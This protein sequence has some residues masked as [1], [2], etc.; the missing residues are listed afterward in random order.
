MCFAVIPYNSN[1]YIF[2]SHSCDNVGK[3]IENGYSVLL[4]FVTIEH[5]FKFHNH[6]ISN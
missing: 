1:N 2:D 3:S 5:V 6:N 4:K